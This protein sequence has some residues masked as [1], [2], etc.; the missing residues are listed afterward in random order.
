MTIAIDLLRLQKVENTSKD[1]PHNDEY[2]MEFALK[3]AKRAALQD[4]VPIGAV[5]VR[6]GKLIAKAFNK[7]EQWHTP[8]GHAELLCIHLASQKLKSW[9]LVDCTLYVTLEPCVMCAG[10]I[11]QSRI[12]RLVFGASDPKGGA[13]RSLFQICED[14]RLNHR[15]QVTGGVCA[16]E[17]GRVLS[18]FFKKKR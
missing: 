12:G 9:R 11:V 5:L 16:E 6:D 4:E 7:R 8:L 3:G 14:S 2:W 13:V 18:E 10:A 1:A 17:C 15:L